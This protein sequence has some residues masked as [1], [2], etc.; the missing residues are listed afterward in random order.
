MFLLDAV[1]RPKS[2][3]IKSSFIVIYLI[4]K[5]CYVQLH[6]ACKVPLSKAL[7]KEKDRYHTAQIIEYLMI[8]FIT[9]LCFST[10]YSSS[11]ELGETN[12]GYLWI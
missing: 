3:K 5:W 7:L 12:T 9:A 4:R 2:A 6:T 1:K 10:F 11:P 8:L